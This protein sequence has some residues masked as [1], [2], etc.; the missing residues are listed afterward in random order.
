MRVSRMTTF[1][2]FRSFASF[3]LL[4]C[5][6]PFSVP[7]RAAADDVKY[8]VKENVIYGRKWG[9]AL[10]M[11]V[12]FPEEKKNGAGV[13][14]VQSGGWISDKGVWGLPYMRELLKRGYTI[15]AV[16]HGSQPKYTIPE[17][18]ED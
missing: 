16:A 4:G 6:L 12:F 3:A 8:E 14:L 9:T 13:I 10:T 1:R 15:F 18:L 11:D 5:V 2:L 7:G 17:I